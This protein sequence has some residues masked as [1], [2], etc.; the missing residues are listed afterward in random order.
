MLQA[1]AAVDGCNRAIDLSPTAIEGDQG[2]VRE[3]VMVFRAEHLA[4]KWI[5]Q[6]ASPWNPAQILVQHD[7]TSLRG[8]YGRV[9][10]WVVLGQPD[11]VDSDRFHVL[12]EPR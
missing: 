1:R 12:T 8:A 2:A 11:R 5:E 3:Q 10:L 7:V 6:H 4:A 9:L